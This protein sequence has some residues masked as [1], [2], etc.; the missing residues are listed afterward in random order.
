MSS[1]CLASL[2]KRNANSQNKGDVCYPTE[3]RNWFYCDC[4]DEVA[5]ELAKDIQSEAISVYLSKAMHEPWH[6]IP[7]MYVRT[8][9]DACV[10]PAYQEYMLQSAG[11]DIEVTMLDSDHSPFQSQP[12]NVAEILKNVAATC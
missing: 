11:A 12:E 7:C 6:D 3:T 5:A 9:R 4:P 2:L 10:V 1:G 8:K